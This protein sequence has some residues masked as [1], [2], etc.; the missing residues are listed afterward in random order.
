MSVAPDK[1]TTSSGKPHI[2]EYLS[3]TNWPWWKKKDTK[4]GGKGSG[5]W[6]WE[7]LQREGEYDPNSFYKILKELRKKTQRI[8]HPPP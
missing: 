6:I 8:F 3:S 5:E 4:L 1:P 2:Y 7:E